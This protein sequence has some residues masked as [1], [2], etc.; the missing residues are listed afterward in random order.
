MKSDFQIQKD[1]MDELKWDPFISISEIGVSVKNGVVTLSGHVDTYSKKLAEHNIVM[2]VNFNGELFTKNLPDSS[3]LPNTAFNT[4]GA[5]IQDDWKISHA[6]TLQ[7][8]LRL[9][10]TNDYGTFV[11]PRLSLMY[12]MNNKVTMRIGGGEGYKTPSLFS[13]EVDDRDIPGIV[14]FGSSIKSEKSL[15][16]NYD[17]NYKTKWSDW[18]LTFNQTFFYNTLFAL[19]YLL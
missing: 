11:L 14:G 2:G 7:S 5:F 8:G 13:A 10:Q 1:V 18:E 4:L 3:Y 16:A 12:K 17:I 9:D 15:G 6:F 19:Y